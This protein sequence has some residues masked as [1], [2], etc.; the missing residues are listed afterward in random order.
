MSIRNV[1]RCAADVALAMVATET[2]AAAELSDA[3]GDAYS[4]PNEAKSGP[5]LY[6]SSTSKS[7]PYF[8]LSNNNCRVNMWAQSTQDH[9]SPNPT[10]NHGFTYNNTM[11]NANAW[12]SVEHW[13]D[14][15]DKTLIHWRVFYATAIPMNNI[16]LTMDVSDPKM[17]YV[18]GSLVPVE[19]SFAKRRLDMVKSAHFAPP[20]GVYDAARKTITVQIPKAAKLTGTGFEWTARTT[21]SFK[22]DDGHAYT[23][24]GS[25]SSDL[26]AG[27]IFYDPAN[28]R[29]IAHSPAKETV[30]CAP[31][32][33]ADPPS[34]KGMVSKEA[35]PV[36]VTIVD[37]LKAN[38]DVPTF[39]CEGEA[40]D[41]ATGLPKG[42]SYDHASRKMTGIAG[43]VGE[44]KVTIGYGIATPAV[45]T[46]SFMPA[47]AP[48]RPAPVTPAPNV[49][50]SV[51]PSVPVKPA[52]A[53]SAPSAK[54]SPSSSAAPAVTT[55]AHKP[56]IAVG[57]KPSVK[58]H[59]SVKAQPGE[60]PKKQTLAYTGADDVALMVA[61]AASIAAGGFLL[62]RRHANR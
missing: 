53:P 7:Q 3:P 27:Q 17:A 58:A 28:P 1:R 55:P 22:A 57:G 30:R 23:V 46:Y 37:P 11:W 62:R 19:Q 48:S 8:T 13:E 43:K 59:P 51:K 45:V 9:D 41:P 40:C 31:T 6:D 39:T 54:P 42:L 24:R 34:V 5:G 15:H 61:A 38:P 25:L 12:Y 2:S 29:G 4:I 20:A 56:T 26:E 52:P 36:K 10:S 21:G 33:T 16:K 50:P 47:P 14:Q 18:E 44:A 35:T 49:T 32:I 60:K